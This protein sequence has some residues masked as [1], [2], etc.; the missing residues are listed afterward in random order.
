MFI[1]RYEIKKI[2]ANEKK[3]CIVDIKKIFR[4]LHLATQTSKMLT[5][6]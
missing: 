4:I 2:N 1:A 3:A 5:K 6:S